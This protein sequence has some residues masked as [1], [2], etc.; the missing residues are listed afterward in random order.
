MTLWITRTCGGCNRNF[1]LPSYVVGPESA[2]C[3]HCNPGRRPAAQPP[4]KRPRLTKK[5]LTD[6]GLA[7]S[8]DEVLYEKFRR[9]NED[10]DRRERSF[11]RT[12]RV[13]EVLL[14]DGKI[15]RQLQIQTI[16]RTVGGTRL[17][18]R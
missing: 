16:Q 7:L 2:R 6:L 4:S 15:M 5:R 17:I 18:V 12:R 9:L 8:M 14:H 3:P 11:E 10:L 1:E 13:F